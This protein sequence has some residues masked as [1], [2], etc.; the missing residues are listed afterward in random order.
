MMSKPRRN[1]IIACV[2]GARTTQILQLL[3]SDLDICCQINATSTWLRVFPLLL[4]KFMPLSNT[5]SWISLFRT[6]A[7]LDQ[8]FQPVKT[9]SSL[10]F[11]CHLANALKHSSIKVYLSVIRSLHRWLVAFS[12]TMCCRVSN[13]TKA[14]IRVNAN[15]SQSS[16]WTL[17]PSTWTC[18][19]TTI[20]FFGLPAVL[21]FLV[22]YALV[23]SPSTPTSIPTSTLLSAM[24]TLTLSTLRWTPFAK[25]AISTLVLRNIIS[26]PWAPLPSIYISVAQRLAH[27]SFYLNWQLLIS[28][29]QS[30]LSAAGVPG[31]YIGH[32]FCIGTVISAASYGLPDHLIK[33]LSKWSSDAY[34]IYIPTLISTIMGLKAYSPDRLFLAYLSLFLV[35]FVGCFGTLVVQGQGLQL[36][37]CSL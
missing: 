15:P 30:T 23:S 17:Y 22:S 10:F 12:Y 31:C 28:G 7:Y 5:I 6:I 24:S 18:L 2:A 35:I 16:W 1:I 4:G 3:L 25:V 29:I 13:V 37:A 21:G 26:A 32:N 27:I 8:L 34:Q 20:Q 19:T 33:I 11:R 36:R 14:L 9:C